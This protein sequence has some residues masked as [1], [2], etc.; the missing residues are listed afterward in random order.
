MADKPLYRQKEWLEKKYWTESLSVAEMAKLA[1]CSPTNITKWMKRLSVKFKKPYRS[2]IYMTVQEAVALSKNM[3]LELFPR[4]SDKFVFTPLSEQKFISLEGDMK[5]RGFFFIHD[6]M[7]KV[8]L[9]MNR[10][11]DK[12]YFYTRTSYIVQSGMQVEAI[13]HFHHLKSRL[14]GMPTEEGPESK[15]YRVPT[16]YVDYYEYIQS[17]EWAEKS[18]A[19]RSSI[20]KCQ[21]CGAA[22]DLQVHHNSYKNLG[23]EPPED[24]IVLCKSCHFI[25]H[26]YRKVQ[27]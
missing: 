9:F 10:F 11:S 17:D 26:K 12:T 2:P 8:S 14:Q 23:N 16:D 4:P 6:D 1:S 21:L 3:E 18:K 13:R 20:L 19:I 22:T 15:M 5:K 24:L 27:S 7:D 25:F